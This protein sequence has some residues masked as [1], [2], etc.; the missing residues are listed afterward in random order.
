MTGGHSVTI[1]GSMRQNLT[2]SPIVPLVIVGAGERSDKG[3]A[4]LPAH[5]L[6]EHV[7]GRRCGA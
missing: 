4:L 1:L 2:V 5:A 7:L 6:V 3:C